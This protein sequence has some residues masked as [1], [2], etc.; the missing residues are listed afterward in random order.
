MMLPHY[1]TEHATLY[2]GD[3][4]EVMRT[5]PDAS[6]DAV[7]TDPPYSLEFMGAAWDRHEN[8][9]AAFGYYLSGLID[10]EG[11]FRV[12]RD[13]RRCEFALKMRDDD[14]WILRRA[15]AFI[16][17]GRITHEPRSAPSNPTASLIIDT[18]DGVAALCSLLL[19]YPLRAK[20]L[21]DFIVWAEAVDEWL[22]MERGN[23]WHG[24]ADRTRLR[25]LS[26]RLR[27][28]RSYSEVAWSGNGF[29]DWC[30]QWAAECLR[31]L[32]PG[33]HL[34]AFGG[35]RT[36]HR[37]A[38]GIED[39]GFEIRD[40]IAWLYGSGFPKSLDVSKAIDKARVE[41]REPVRIVCRA[42]RA[43]MDARGLSSRDLVEHFDGCHPRLVD[44]WAARD[45]DS[46]PALPKWEQWETLRN[47]LDP[48]GLAAHD[49]E[50]WRLNGRK[51]APGDVWQAAEVVGTAR[52]VDT[53][54]SRLGFAGATY[55][56]T[57]ASRE[58]DL[59]A[60]SDQATAWQGWG[61]AL[62]PAFEPI[63]VARKPLVGTVAANV[64][65]HGTGA[66]H[67][68][69]NRVPMT[70]EDAAA[71]ERMGGYG[72]SG[73]PAPD[74]PAL[75][76]PAIRTGAKAHAAGRWPANVILDLSQAEALDAQTAGMRAGTPST[77]G[78][79]SA[80]GILGYHGGGSGY[81]GASA[82]GYGETEGGASRFFYTAKASSAE[83]PSAD[84]VQHPTVKPLDLMKWLVRLVTPPGGTVLEPFAGS[85]TTVEAALTEGFHCIAIERE[86]TYMPLI[87][88]RMRRPMQGSLF[89]L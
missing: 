11:H 46:Q 67:I 10:G 37:L 58:F 16:G 34:L 43:A 64:L 39:A 54:A 24:A 2:L 77:G 71:I 73:S 23:R 20:K 8:E 89:D 83:R 45:T 86:A 68:D 1:S 61:T 12:D 60:A 52:G 4:I 40:S 26:E 32:K 87:E 33:G 13:G 82:G 22:T 3:C 44:H 25:V 59:K 81:A 30:R 9:D 63:I 17:H 5:L 84:G 55:G 36:F 41:D 72:R 21:R 19:R 56:G 28:G 76:G 31:I 42:I 57:S 50:V 6:I 75:M 35:T 85:G 53:T 38:A 27:T 47:L 14:E 88:A 62:K 79:G 78:T 65:A 7:V 48:E 74:G 18:K 51:G 66:L 69:A 49:A 70:D 15:L 80:S 29:Q